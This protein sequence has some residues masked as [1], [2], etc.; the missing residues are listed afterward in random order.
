MQATG[1]AEAVDIAVIVAYMAAVLVL[2]YILKRYSAK[3]MEGYF[4]GGRRLPGWANGFSYAAACMNSDVAPAYI[5]WTVGTG[6]FIGWF[7]IARFGLAF[8]IAGTLFAIFWRKLNLFTAPEFYELRF[9]GRAGSAVRGWIAFRSAFIAVV[10]WSGTGLLGMSKVTEPVFGWDKTETFAIVIPMVLVYVLMSG[11]LGVVATDILHTTVM[12][13]SG[14]A[15]CVFGLVQIGGPAELLAK[16]TQAAGPDVTGSLPPFDHPELGMAAILILFLGTGI[17]Y[18]GDVAPMG[19]AME[20]QRVFS[21]RTYRDSAK[22]FVWTECVLWLLLVTITLPGL[23]AIAKWP[24]LHT[25]TRSVRETVYGLLLQTYLPPAFLG[26]AVAALMAALMST[27]SANYNFGSQVATSDL[28]RRFIH[29][30][31]TENHYVRVGRIFVVAICALSVFVA[32]KGSSIITIAIF[33]VGLSA[34][35]YAANWGQWWWWRFNGYSRLSASFGGPVIFV[36]IRFVVAP[37]FEKNGW[38]TITEW[39]AILAAMALTTL[40]WVSVTLL[41]PPQDEKI[42]MEFYRRAQPLGWWGPIRKKLGIP[43]EHAHRSLIIKGFGIAVL[44][45]AWAAAAVFV[46]SNLFVGK[47]MFALKIG[48]VGLVLMLVFWRMFGRYMSVLEQ[49]TFGDTKE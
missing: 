2:G 6:L 29:R 38:G 24:E 45:T 11:Y 19:S 33:L 22:M 1:K 34:A 30:K 43:D 26:L 25:A 49:R 7:Y 8:M 36:L 14:I 21:C 20:G 9:P 37:T 3:N 28:Y 13:F 17:G 23:V 32:Y 39:Y 4:L 16:L 44:G 46:L 40:L 5:A 35:E 12:I 27:L 47:F 42:L 10:A 18:G 15:L 48:A 31:G 41:T